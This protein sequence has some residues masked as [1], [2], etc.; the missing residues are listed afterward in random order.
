MSA[1][2][3]KIELYMFED[4]LE[5][6]A[7]SR[8]LANR[9]IDPAK[10]RDDPEESLK[11]PRVEIKAVWNGFSTEHYWINQVTKEKWPDVGEGRLYFKIVT[12]RGLKEQNHGRLRGTIRWLMQDVRALSVLMTY[13]RVEKMLEQG[14]VP[15]FKQDEYQDI[16]AISFYV[17][18]SILPTAFP[19]N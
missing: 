10:Q 16:S 19:Q 12:R 15:D 5:T 6:A 8:L 17:K 14:T 7:A 2:P 1:T 18:M 13:H 11:T 3:P 4:V 9:V